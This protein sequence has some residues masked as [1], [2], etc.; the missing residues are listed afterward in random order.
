MS[1]VESRFN[2]HVTRVIAESGDHKA[3]DDE[4]QDNVIAPCVKAHST[5]D[6]EIT[7][8]HVDEVLYY[9]AGNCHLAWDND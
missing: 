3:I 5:Q 7:A 4:I 1:D 6:H 9:L 8:N 2:R